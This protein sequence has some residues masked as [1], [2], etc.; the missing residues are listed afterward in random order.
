MFV[1]DVV[2]IQCSKLFKGLGVRCCLYGTLHSK[3][4]LESLIRVGRSP[5]FGIPPVSRMRKPTLQVR[6]MGVE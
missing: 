4:L 3:E 2:H 6:C 5:D 1:I